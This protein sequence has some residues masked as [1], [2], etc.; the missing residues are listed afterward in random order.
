[1]T[2]GV[3]GTRPRFDEQKEVDPQVTT[4]TS[5]KTVDR[6]PETGWAEARRRRG[7]V[8]VRTWV[9]AVEET[10]APRTARTGPEANIVRGED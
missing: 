6:R 5:E 3:G 4:D 7:T 8:P 9:P 1:L 2:G 10:G